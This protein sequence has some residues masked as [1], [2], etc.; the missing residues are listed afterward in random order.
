MPVSVI[1]SPTMLSTRRIPAVLPHSRKTPVFPGAGHGP[2]V[3][4]HDR[5]SRLISDRLRHE[6]AQF[7]RS[8]DLH[9]HGSVGVGVQSEARAVVPQHGGQGLY[10]HSVL[11][12]QCCEGMPLRYN[13]DKPEKPR[14]I[15]G[16]EVF[17]LVFSSFSKPKNHTE[18]SRIIGG[19]SLTTNE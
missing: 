19:V 11:E 18:I 1:H 5:I 3:P 8:F 14:R 4:L 6:S 7:V 12:R 10:I 15:K 9:L 17:S 2:G 13:Y 16:F